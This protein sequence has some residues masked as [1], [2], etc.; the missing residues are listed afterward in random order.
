MCLGDVS[1]GKKLIPLLFLLLSGRVLAYEFPIEVAEY[2]DDVKIVA[3]LDKKD[4]NNTSQW[5]PFEGQPPLSIYD[6]LQAVQKYIISNAEY[7]ENK[8]IGI[9]LKRIPH[10]EKNWHYLVKVK[11][12]HG[13]KMQPHFFVVLMDGKVISALR[14]PESIK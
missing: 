5:V 10:H 2:I 8:L 6:A 9:E 11:Y 1:M 13:D 7:V 4:V 12:K 14:K 3:Y